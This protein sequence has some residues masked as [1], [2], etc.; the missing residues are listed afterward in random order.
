MVQEEILDHAV[1]N[2]ALYGFLAM[3]DAHFAKLRRLV[4]VV[5]EITGISAVRKLLRD[6]ELIISTQLK[7]LEIHNEVG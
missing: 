4:V 6:P 5:H 1:G 3:L 7:F 2:L